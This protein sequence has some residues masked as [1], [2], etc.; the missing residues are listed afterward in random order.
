MDLLD[1]SVVMPV[2]N[3][4]DTVVR[5]VESVLDN[6]IDQLEI[7]VIDDGS[8]DGSREVVAAMADPC[9]EILSSRHQG[10]V[11]ALN[12]GV[13]RAKSSFIARMDADDVS[14]PGRL[15]HQLRMLRAGE[16]DVVGS[17]V[18]IVDR[19]GGPVPS[20]ARYEQWINEHTSHEQ[21]AAMRYVESPLVHPTVMARREVFAL[22]Y[23]DGPWPEDYDLWLRA[24][25]DGYRFI[26]S[27]CVLLDW[28]E[29]D[30]R[31]TRTSDRYSPP[32]FDRCRRMH[33]LAGPLKDVHQ[34]DLW[35]A[36]RTGKPWLRW[37]NK[38][39]LSVRRV[40]EIDPKK[41]GQTIHTAPVVHPDEMPTA[42]GTLMLMAVGAEGA[43]E[44]I[45]PH[46][47]GRGYVL[48]LDAWFVA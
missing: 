37:L 7:I 21:I 13:E 42:D 15:Q 23:R 32:A 43:R 4:V 34:V 38:Q 10:L 39:S 41:V 1:L 47:R 18:R 26:K 46:L 19:L 36:G 33:L 29:R 16:A 5:A 28:T 22:Q 27:S 14:R 31:L 40:Y 24:I 30:G 35:G 12:L 8:T 17:A 25:S 9:I 44:Q 11:S 6:E 45:E 48:G 3:A 20:M 2:F